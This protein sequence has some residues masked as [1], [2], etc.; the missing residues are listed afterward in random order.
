MEWSGGEERDVDVCFFLESF[1]EKNVKGP[2]SKY[3]FPTL[4]EQERV[5]WC[6]GEERDVDV[7][8]AD[9]LCLE[10]EATGGEQSTLANGF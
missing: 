3:F 2:W 9:L 1:P 10:T 5:E 7:C 8:S 4:D 6:G